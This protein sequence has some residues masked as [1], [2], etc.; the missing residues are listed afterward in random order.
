MFHNEISVNGWEN[1]FT[2][3]TVNWFYVCLA[4]RLRAKFSLAAVVQ[5]RSEAR[6]AVAKKLL[7]N[8]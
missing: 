5:E 6:I 8:N 7:R 3:S 4:F 1:T 2:H